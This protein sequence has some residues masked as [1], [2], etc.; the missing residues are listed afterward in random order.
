MTDRNIIHHLTTDLGVVQNYQYKH[1]QSLCVDNAI[2]AVQID[3]SMYEHTDTVVQNTAVYVFETD[4]LTV[5]YC[6]LDDDV[7]EQYRD[8]VTFTFQADNNKWSTF[9]FYMKPEILKE[10]VA[11]MI[12]RNAALAKENTDEQDS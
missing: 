6:R 8:L 11:N 9:N 7:V 2:N 4:N 5:G 12:D 1:A 10:A 3:I